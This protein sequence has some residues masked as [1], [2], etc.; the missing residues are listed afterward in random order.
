MIQVINFPTANTYLLDGNSTP[1]TVTSNNA[2]GYFR[3]KINIDDAPF[4]E[5]GW[6][7]KDDFTATKDLLYLLNAYFRPYFLGQFTTGL[8]EQTNFKKKTSIIIEE[9]NINTDAILGNVTLPDFYL[10]YNVKSAVF[11][12]LDKLYIFG[13]K[14]SQINMKSDG[15][16]VIPFY[17]NAN[18]ENVKVT[19][20]DDLDNIIHFQGV[21]NVTGK[22]VY[23]YTLKLSET[24]LVSSILYLKAKIT[25]GTT[26][27]EKIYTILR[28]PSYEVKEVVYQNNFGFYIPAYFDG[29]FEDTSGYKVESYERNDTSTAVYA[30]KENGSYTINTGN[31]SIMHKDIVNEIANSIDC[32]F[33][34]DG[35]YL[36]VNTETKKST[37]LKSRLN[38]YAQDLVFSFSAG[39]P[40]LNLNINGSMNGQE[41]LIP[42]LTAVAI[43]FIQEEENGGVPI[44]QFNSNY[45]SNF[46]LFQLFYQIRQS[47][48]DNWSPPS[49][50][51][52]ANPLFGYGLYF[53]TNHQLRLYSY[54]NGT[55]IYSNIL[56]YTP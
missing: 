48:N 45:T 14:S 39:L 35:K 24:P 23:I 43:N 56:T 13:L 17:V 47:Q 19:I 31:L 55:I 21:N 46:P 53:G 11:N 36:R 5:Q 8:L 52:I 22:K 34:N 51:S 33:N 4:D 7:R 28:L 10:L 27:F 25:V 26:K 16:I 18:S 54:Y 49:E 29:D 42:I 50:I 41:F 6:S 12:D 44:F 2:N 37:N 32:Y 3:A 15:V 40:F 9:R 38:N 1:I 30:V 20:Y